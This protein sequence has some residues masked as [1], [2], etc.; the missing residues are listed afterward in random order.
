MNPC[1]SASDVNCPNVFSNGIV[2]FALSQITFTVMGPVLSDA[3]VE[4]DKTV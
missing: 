4:S 1:F 2:P 3:G